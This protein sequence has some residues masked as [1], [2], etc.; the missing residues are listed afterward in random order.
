MIQKLSIVLVYE[1]LLYCM[2]LK[3]ALILFHR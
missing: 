2:I 3:S 1:R